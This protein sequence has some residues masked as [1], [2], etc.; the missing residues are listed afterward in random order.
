[1]ALVMA[2]LGFTTGDVYPICSMYGIFTNIDPISEPDVGKDSIH[3]AS[4]YG[5]LHSINEV[6]LVLVSKWY[7]GP[8]MQGHLLVLKSLQC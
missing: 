3:G 6:F 5:I 2:D 8:Q 7:F 4:G 1:M